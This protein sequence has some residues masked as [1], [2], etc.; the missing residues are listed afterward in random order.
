MLLQVVKEQKTANTYS[1]VDL[2]VSQEVTDLGEDDGKEGSGDSDE[3]NLQT[4]Q[5]ICFHQHQEN[6]AR[7]VVQKG[8]NLEPSLCGKGLMD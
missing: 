1:S 8:R 5:S 4:P 6:I 3:D 7:A 2:E